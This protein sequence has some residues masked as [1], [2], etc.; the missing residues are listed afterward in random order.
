M[1]A[2]MYSINGYNMNERAGQ[3]SC[4]LVK[5]ENK[6]P[7]CSLLFDSV[8]H[9]MSA[10]FACTALACISPNGDTNISLSSERNLLN[11]TSML[12]DRG[13][14][15]GLW[16]YLLILSLVPSA[17]SGGLGSVLT[18][19]LFEASRVLRSS[20]NYQEMVGNVGLIYA[21]IQKFGM[22]ANFH[23]VNTAHYYPHCKAG[24]NQ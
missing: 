3:I 18:D 15:C 12:H 19:L 6:W 7:I 20:I 10:L 9:Q 16:Y 5:G 17:V 22:S 1:S 13:I 23:I 2:E 21:R 14:L 24:N 8:L 4:Y 11:N